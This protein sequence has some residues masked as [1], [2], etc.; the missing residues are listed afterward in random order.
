[1]QE[2]GIMGKYSVPESVRKL[3]PK[4]TMVKL[5]SNNYY[6]YE[7]KTVKG[8][9]GKRHTKMGSLIGCIKEGIGFIPNNSFI[10]D[11][12][13]ST[14]DYGEYA[15]TLVNSKNIFSMLNE[16]FNPQ[17]A[18]MIYV[19]SI[20]HF[21]NGFTYIKNIRDY[22]DMSI[23]S[24]VFP[25]LK[26]G[27]ETVSNL[28]ESLGSRQ[29]SIL[30]MEERLVKLSS[31]QIAIDGHVIGST[32]ENN[33]L[34]EKGYKFKKIGEPQIN[35]LM[36]YDINSKTP[37]ISRI[38]EG[39]SNDKLS[40]KDFLNQTELKNMLFIVDR[41]FY[42]TENISIFS[43]NGNA[44]IIPLGKNLKTRKTAVKSIEMN[45]RFVY[46]KGKKSSVIECKDE[47]IN[48]FR[49]LTYRDLNESATEQANYIRHMERGEKSY[50]TEGFEKN[51][52]FMG[53]TVLQTSLTENTPQEVYELYKK[54][55][56]IE[57]F[58]NY[59]KNQAGY[60]S[61][62]IDNYCKAQGLAFIMLV[63]SLIYCEMEKRA[64]EINGKSLQDCLLEARMVKTHKRLERWSVTNCLKRQ[65]ELF[66]HFGVPLTIEELLHT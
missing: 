65:K 33:D 54:R 3:K 61:L 50:T 43:S 41:G 30:K 8:D 35:L 45:E 21:I 53:V 2:V 1:M 25:S 62:H 58:Y 27:K 55:W 29:T 23:L 6:V 34:S 4:G 15:I 32:S 28:Y 42:S 60:N 44:Y 9:D 51:R 20:V 10:C 16:F 52:D 39:A 17:D 22:F 40:V 63:S 26:L 59:L 46:Q 31:G 13:I 36:A 37:L 56:G 11:S 66:E 19:I 49:V 5:I 64:K 24:L 12:E 7:Y 57:T 14:L 18:A 47:I 48:G 38:Y